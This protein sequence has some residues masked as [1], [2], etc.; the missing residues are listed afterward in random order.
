MSGTDLGHIL[1]LPGSKGIALCCT[2]LY[3]CSQE[4]GCDLHMLAKNASF[5]LATATAPKS[6]K[7]GMYRYLSPLQFKVVFFFLHNPSEGILN[8]SVNC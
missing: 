5:I 6:D 8:T 2:E 4:T 3:T 1:A 7:T